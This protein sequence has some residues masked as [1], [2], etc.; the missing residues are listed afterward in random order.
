MTAATNPVGITPPMSNSQLTPRA[1]LPLLGFYLS[2]VGLFCFGLLVATNAN[3]LIFADTSDRTIATVH[4]MMLG[5]LSIAVLGAFN[6]FIPV[7][8]VKRMLSVKLGYAGTILFAIGVVLICTGFYFSKMSIVGIAGATL[9]TAIILNAVN[10]FVPLLKAKPSVS[11]NGLR[12]SMGF[13]VVTGCFGITYA[14]DESS[15]WFNIPGNLALAH[16]TFGLI[17]FLSLAYVSVSEKLW[18]M[19][20]LSHRSGT[21][22]PQATIYL[23]ATGAT[24]T[25]LS[26][27]LKIWP[28]LYIGVGILIVSIGCHLLSFFMFMRARKRKIELLQ[29]YIIAS[30]L[31]LIVSAAD[32]IAIGVYGLH[33]DTPTFLINSLIGSLAAWVLLAIIGHMHKIIPFITYNYLRSHGIRKNKYDKPL[34]FGDLFNQNVARI[35]IYF[36]VSGCVILVVGLFVSNHILVLVSGILFSLT[37]IVT[38]LNFGIGGI[39]GNRLAERKG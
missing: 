4:M 5:T 9:M 3:S 16:A 11:V 12:L 14:F 31:F 21:K 7:V 32:V 22:I 23:M 18:P 25:A 29:I 10:L 2:L 20:L 30:L 37:A 36:A 17:G 24:I 39:N 34:S 6:Q 33:A 26:L 35:D 13:L 27:A 8:T 28:V 1:S 15:N 38:I 19:F